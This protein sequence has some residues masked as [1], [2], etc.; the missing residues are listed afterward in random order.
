MLRVILR[1][2]ILLLLQHVSIQPGS[3][4]VVQITHTRPNLYMEVNV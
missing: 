4:I 1:R 3:S 2:K